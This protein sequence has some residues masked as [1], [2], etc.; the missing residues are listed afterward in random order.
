MNNKLPKWKFMMCL[1]TFLCGGAAFAG[2]PPVSLVDQGDAAYAKREDPVQAKIALHYY[3]LALT[4]NPGDVQ[5]AWKAS[6]AAYWV[7]DVADSR[8]DKLQFF[9]RG[10]DLA[11]EGI[12][13]NPDSVESHY[14]LGCNQGSYGDARGVLKSLFLV[15]PIRRE[16]AEVNR[17]NDRY[18]GGGG[19]RV[20]GVVDYKVPG[21]AGGGKKRA[22]EELNK[23]LAIDPKNPYTHYYLAEFFKETGEKDKARAEIAALQALEVNPELVPDLHLE[24][25]RGKKLIE[26]L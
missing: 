6:R 25:A 24:Q 9:Q 26:D 19:Y 20:L 1:T 18:D 13:K 7:G 21:F 8:A 23:S 4:A 16:M 3:E 22:L 15:N 17:L 5:A 11:Q 2:N 12:A 14:W 10:I